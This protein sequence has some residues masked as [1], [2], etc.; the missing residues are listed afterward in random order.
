MGAAAGGRGGCEGFCR[1]FCGEH[2]ELQIIGPRKQSIIDFNPGEVPKDKNL[3]SILA[4]YPRKKTC[5]ADILATRIIGGVSA[6]S[7]WD[8]TAPGPPGVPQAHAGRADPGHQGG[9]E[10]SVP[11]AWDP[12]APGPPGVPKAHA[13]RTDPGAQGQSYTFARG[14]W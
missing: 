12:T 10:V 14:G 3:S 2:R 11:S 6:P 4:K 7:A 8:P 13:G 9:G 1:G 5:E